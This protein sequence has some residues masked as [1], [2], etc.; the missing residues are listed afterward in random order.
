M[1]LLLDFF[2]IIIFFGVYKYT[3]DIIMATAI[4]IPAT[5][6]QILYTWI[7][8]HRIEKM[9]FVTLVLVIIMG[10]AT[11]IFQDKTFIQWKPTV[12]NW[13]FGAAFLGSH[14]IGAK[15]IIERIM[16]ANIDL[17]QHVWKTLNFAWVFFFLLMGV[18]N[19]IVAYNFSEETWVNFKL[20]GMLGLTVVFIVIQGLYM[21]KYINNTE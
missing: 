18:I 6:L 7:K 5:L 19:L 4:L 11:V 20:F 13:L 9:Q 14:F 12:V 21:S 10:G 16:S 8:E 15:T 17:P 1:K 2:P 3:G